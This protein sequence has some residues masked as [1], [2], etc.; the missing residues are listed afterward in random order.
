MTD[1]FCQMSVAMIA[2]ASEQTCLFHTGHRTAAQIGDGVDA[3]ERPDAD[4]LAAVAE[5]T[6]NS[7]KSGVETLI[8]HIFS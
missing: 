8:F 3:T 5:R 2:L 7:A 6:I 4:A 1:I